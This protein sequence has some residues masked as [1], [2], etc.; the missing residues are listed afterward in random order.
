MGTD[1]S[2]GSEPFRSP[3]SSA[4]HPAKSAR[5]CRGFS[6]VT[7]RNQ[8]PDHRFEFWRSL[9]PQ[10]HMDPVNNDCRRNFNGN[11]LHCVSGSGAS[12]VFCSNDDTYAHFGRPK[13][14]FI[15]VSLTLAGSAEVRQ[16]SDTRVIV[17]PKA[18]LIALDGGRTLS[19]RSRGHSVIS[20]MLPRKLVL[21]AFGGEPRPLSD[22]LARFQQK[23]IAI[24]LASHLKEMALQGNQ[25]DPRS[26]EVAMHTAVSMALMALARSRKSEDFFSRAEYG[27]ALFTAARRYIDL[28]CFDHKL[29]AAE[30]ARELGCS[31][32]QL[33]RVF[34]GRGTAVGQ[35]LKEARLE[36][37]A[38][39][40]SSSPDMPVKL[41]AFRSG[42]ADAAAFARAFRMHR[43]TS[44]TEYRDSFR[45]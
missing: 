24:L 9:F 25:L 22:G 1:Q 44:P 14:D 41:V 7:T 2:G 20:L 19:T 35:A 37:A 26:S 30:V 6:A 28:N 32:A 36:R 3:V 40:L 4:G 13:G 5:E 11:L 18:G 17:S 21:Q 34:S 15:M 16:G 39:L 45:S 23:G 33:Y 27:A 42:Y 31:R 8:R 43:G 29:T 38:T 10:I 12:F